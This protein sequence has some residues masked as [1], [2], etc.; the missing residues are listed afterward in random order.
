MAELVTQFTQSHFHHSRSGTIH[1]LLMS[2]IE[3]ALFKTV[4]ESTHYNQTKAATILGLSRPT[5]RERLTLYF[6]DTYCKTREEKD[7]DHPA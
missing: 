7:Y 6:G 4:L 2:A 3:P 5:F 1:E